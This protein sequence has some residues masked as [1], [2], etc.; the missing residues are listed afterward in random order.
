[1]F[2]SSCFVS[3][4]GPSVT[5]TVHTSPWA[6]Q[7]PGH[8]LIKN[9]N[10]PSSKTIHELQ[11]SNSGRIPMVQGGA[12]GSRPTSSV[13]PRTP[14]PGRARPLGHQGTYLPV[15]C[16]RLFARL[17]HPAEPLAL[18]SGPTRPADRDVGSSHAALRLA[19]AGQAISLRLGASH[20]RPI[21]PAQP[22]VQRPP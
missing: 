6:P 13:A 14:A 2:E 7:A 11:E 10:P 9:L 18:D 4:D 15:A 3:R 12:R 1:M 22:A 8:S 5:V 19:A 20:V 21:R 17:Q 16:L